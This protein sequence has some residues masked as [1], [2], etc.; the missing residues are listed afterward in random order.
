LDRLRV[1]FYRDDRL[2][3][4]NFG[5]INTGMAHGVAGVAAALRA[6]SE[7]APWVR[8]Q[9][10]PPLRRVCRWL[11]EESFNDSR[12]LL[13]WTPG[14]REGAP[15]PSGASSRQAWC[16]GAPGV[17]WALWESAR[18]LDDPGLRSFAE[19][20]MRTFCA[21]FAEERYIDDAPADDALA[22]CHGAAGTL[23]IAD[24][25]ARSAKLTE[26]ASLAD[27][28]EAYL[29]ARLDEVQALAERNMTLLTG[30]SGILAVLLTR[31]G[32]RRDWLSQF[33]LR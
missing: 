30:A 2:R 14:G 32:G 11:M 7:T 24:A 5:R 12:G 16:Y 21:A 3:S 23:A 33:A 10:G 18:V 20:A 27:R 4:W 9:L 29:L 26:A 28:L 31:H 19:D 22:F 8:Q 1:G 15:P 25:F 13:T 6:A 17:A